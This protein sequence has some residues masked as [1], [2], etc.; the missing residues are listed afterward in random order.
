MKHVPNGREERKTARNWDP[1]THEEKQSGTGAPGHMTGRAV[2]TAGGDVRRSPRATRGGSE[3][4][5]VRAQHVEAT[6][7][8]T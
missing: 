3:N 7:G 8:E 1:R 4:G 6:R 5:A 2:P